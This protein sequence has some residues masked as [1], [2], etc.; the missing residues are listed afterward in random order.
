MQTRMRSPGAVS[1]S[2]VKTHVNYL[3]DLQISQSLEI[4]KTWDTN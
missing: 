4:Q 3:P 1:C 2:P